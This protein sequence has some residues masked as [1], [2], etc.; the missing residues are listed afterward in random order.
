MSRKPLFPAAQQTRLMCR[1]LDVSEEN[2]LRRV[3]LR[4]DYLEGEDTGV[5]GRIFLAL[6]E[7]LA[8]ETNRDDMPL[9]LA[10]IAASRPC[11]S[12]M[13]AF[14]SSPV[15]RE[16]LERLALFK[17]LVA[18][19]KLVLKDVAEGFSISFEPSDS[20]L[21]MPES[22][23]L[24][25]LIY[26][27]EIARVYTSENIIPVSVKGP[28]AGRLHDRLVDYFGRAPEVSQNT[29]L[30]LR[31]PDAGLPLISASDALWEDFEP[32]LQ[33]LLARTITPAT[34]TERVEGVL[35][36][37]LPT[38]RASADDVCSRL[39]M[40]RRSLQRRLHEE[41]KSYRRVLDKTRADLARAYLA[42]GEMSVEEISYL[43]AY[44]DPNSF[45]RAFQNWTG[46]T[47]KQARVSQVN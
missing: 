38:G 18:P 39:N 1:L 23:R 5:D 25:E 24:F 6:W 27:I 19:I 33:R 28:D 2:I 43:L 14:T 10:Q 11:N 22:F 7:A 42:Q 9:H 31:P 40:S 41:G 12:P 37:L 8:A 36:D 47:P 21:F 3:G 34:T 30:V 26:F 32:T 17:P 4:R 44:R 16:G 29:E 13:I 35:R 46:M 45:Y 15:L 20:S